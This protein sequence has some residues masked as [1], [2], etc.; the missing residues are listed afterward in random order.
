MARA[1]NGASRLLPAHHTRHISPRTEV[2]DVQPGLGVWVATQDE[3]S[4]WSIGSGGLYLAEDSLDRPAWVAG[5]TV[6]YDLLAGERWAVGLGALGGWMDKA[7]WTGPVAVPWAF[8]RWDVGDQGG[9]FLGLR[10]TYIPRAGRRRLRV[11][12]LR[13]RAGVQMVSNGASRQ[14]DALYFL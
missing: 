6:E 2:D 10:A 4:R 3:G 5:G 1:G 13:A 14:R 11:L 7:E 12:G 8:G 9:L